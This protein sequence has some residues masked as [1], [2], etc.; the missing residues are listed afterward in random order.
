MRR[1]RWRPLRSARGAPGVVPTRYRPAVARLADLWRGAVPVGNRGFQVAY[2]HP[3]VPTNI[4][5]I[6]NHSIGSLCVLVSGA[7]KIL[8]RAMGIGPTSEAWEASILPLYDARSGVN[9][10]RIAF[11]PRDA[12]LLRNSHPIAA[13]N[14]RRAANV[15]ADRGCRQRKPAPRSHH[16]VSTRHRPLDRHQFRRR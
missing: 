12:Q 16:Q 2:A 4:S 6:S 14:S 8:E 5:P 11:V 3:D 15:R 10:R 1:S 9:V 13:E 7:G